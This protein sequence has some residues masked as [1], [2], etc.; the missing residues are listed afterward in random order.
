LKKANRYEAVQPSVLGNISQPQQEIQYYT[1]SQLSR[2][3]SVKELKALIGS[4][5]FYRVSWRAN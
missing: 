5:P 1:S 2:V 3:I 4:R